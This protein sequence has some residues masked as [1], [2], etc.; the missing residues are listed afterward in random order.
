M[1]PQRFITHVSQLPPDREPETAPATESP[2]SS[3]FPGLS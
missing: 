2:G 1:P 3:R